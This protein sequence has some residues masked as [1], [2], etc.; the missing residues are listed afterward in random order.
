MNDIENRTHTRVLQFEYI[1]A[2]SIDGDTHPGVAG[3]NEV[4]ETP[5][6][7]AAWYFNFLARRQCPPPWKT[8]VKAHSILR[9]SNSL[10]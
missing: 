3:N 8:L 1:A 10:V 2:P 7:S 5:P 4:G 6:A 9:S